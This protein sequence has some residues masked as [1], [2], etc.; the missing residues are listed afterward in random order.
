MPIR[1]ENKA[2]YP[3]D[4]PQISRAIRDRASNSCE[5]CGAPNGTTVLRGTSEDYHWLP[6]YAV[7]APMG[8]IGAHVFSALDGSV[9]DAR[10]VADLERDGW[11]PVKIVLTVAHLDHQ[12]ENCDPANLRAWCQRCHNAYDAP[13]RRAG[14]KAR[15]R[16]A[17]AVGDMFP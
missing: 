14:T 15:R 7:P 16:S 12:P 3:K 17:N 6:R 2:R 8:S 10:V 9:L 11:K 1:D 5:K 13:M 4:W